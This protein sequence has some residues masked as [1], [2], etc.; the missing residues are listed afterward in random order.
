MQMRSPL[1][2]RGYSGGAFTVTDFTV[3]ASTAHSV[4]TDPS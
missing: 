1:L 2:F 4:N 3:T